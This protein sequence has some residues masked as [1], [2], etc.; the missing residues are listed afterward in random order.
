MAAR[1]LIVLFRIIRLYIQ[2]SQHYV[3]LSDG[4]SQSSKDRGKHNES[5]PD[6]QKTNRFDNRK[7][8]SRS[9]SLP[10]RSLSL[11][12]PKPYQPRFRPPES[13]RVKSYP[14]SRSRPPPPPV[15][16]FRSSSPK[17]MFSDRNVAYKRPPSR[18]HHS[19]GRISKFRS[20]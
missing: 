9:E 2:R 19:E 18:S 10:F 4:P 20:R 8:T 12:S 6:G 1:F 13:I 16:R 17:K 5:S 3:E 15:P 14:P 11:K 7:S